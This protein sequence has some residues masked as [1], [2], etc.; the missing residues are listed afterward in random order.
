MLAIKYNGFNYAKRSS[1]RPSDDRKEI[2]GVGIES[3]GYAGGFVKD[4]D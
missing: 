1:C 3:H 2:A 4:A